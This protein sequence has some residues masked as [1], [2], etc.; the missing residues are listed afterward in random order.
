M[1]ALTDRLIRDWDTASSEPRILP[2][3]ES[4]YMSAVGNDEFSVSP[5]KGKT[6]RRE[7]PRNWYTTLVYP[8]LSLF[9]D[10]E[11]ANRLSKVALNS[12][13]WLLRDRPDDKSL[14]ISVFGRTFPNPI[15]MA[16][17]WDKDADKFAGLFDVGFGF[18]EVGTVTPLAQLGNDR[19]R[20]FRLPKDSAIINRMGFPSEGLDYVVKNLS[21][22]PRRGIL[23]VNVGANKDSHDRLADYAKCA[24]AVAP[25]A[26]YLV[27]NVSSP[28]TPGLRD[29]QAA[30]LLSELLRR[31]QDSLRN[32]RP[33]LL[34]KIAP[35]ASKAA[36]DAIVRVCRDL[37]IDGLI[38]GNT[39]TKRPTQ[40]QTET[41][42]KDEVGGLS[43]SPLTVLSTEVLRYAAQ[44]VEKQFPLVGCGGV[45]DGDDAYA[46]IRAGASLIQLYTALIYG[47]PPLLRSIKDRLTA[48]L[49]ADRFTS[50]AEAVGADL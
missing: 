20:V 17:G 41:P 12:C 48:R 19:V 27:C 35:D 13:Q 1:N 6:F 4:G 50:V 22:R 5:A 31:V 18:V 8:A 28:N 33:P 26:D 2:P 15:G 10:P 16:A 21:K 34:V 36:L 24:A 11:S 23:G 39:T 29:L 38:V 3:S 37:K 47:G 49:K 14:A 45:F 25:Y 40:L 42:R 7:L 9:G 43:G 30:E 32:D 44:R 46:K